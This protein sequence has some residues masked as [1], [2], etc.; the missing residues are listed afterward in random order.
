MALKVRTI[1]LEDQEQLL[2]MARTMHGESPRYKG[3]SFSEEKARNIIT[4]LTLRLGDSAG[5]LAET[6]GQIV[7]MIG[8][9]VVE[10]FFGHDKYATDFV[11][12]VLPEHRGGWAAPRL[13]R[14]FEE[15]ARDS[16]ATEICLG[17][18]TGI[19]MEETVCLYERLG[20][21]ISSVT[22]IKP[23][24]QNHVRPQDHSV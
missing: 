10:D 14:A 9:A 12:Y 1:H 18:S 13:I 19:H 6:R 16:G 20:Y 24:D 15:W 17:V 8:G 21:K 11:L 4:M 23:R 3:R 7:G 2:A 22:L 5:F